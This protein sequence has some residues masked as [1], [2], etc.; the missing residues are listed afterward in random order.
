MNI[1]VSIKVKGKLAATRT[2]YEVKGLTATGG[3]Q[4]VSLLKARS[5]ITLSP[6]EGGSNVSLSIK[7]DG[8]VALAKKFKKVGNSDVSLLRDSLSEALFVKEI[9]PAPKAKPALKK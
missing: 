4:L 6:V 9:A 5:G 8:K 1:A 7:T 3:N 2:K